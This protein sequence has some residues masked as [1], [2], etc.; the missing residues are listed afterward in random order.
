MRTQDVLSLDFDDRTG[1]VGALGAGIGVVFSLVG[2]GNPLLWASVGG[3]V[4][5][6]IGLLVG[7]SR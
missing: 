5:L 7:E 1:I 2:D 3:V 4:E 6:M